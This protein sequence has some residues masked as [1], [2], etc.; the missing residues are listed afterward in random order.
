MHRAV[1]A[2]AGSAATAPLGVLL[3]LWSARRSLFKIAF[4]G[5]LAMSAITLLTTLVLSA[6]PSLILAVYRTTGIVIGAAVTTWFEGQDPTRSRNRLARLVPLAILPY[7][8][9]V[10]FVNDLLTP[11]WRTVPQALA[12]LNPF[13]LLPFYHHYIVSKA[14]AATSVAVHLLTFAPIGVM[15]ALRRGGGRGEVWMAG[16]LAALMSFARAT[17]GPSRDRRHQRGILS[18]RRLWLHCSQWIVHLV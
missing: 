4:V 3:A 11:H 10:F 2:L 5:F 1:V 9:A 14:Q 17:G 18:G 13:G 8:L 16:I 12:A 7:G 6:A 15:V